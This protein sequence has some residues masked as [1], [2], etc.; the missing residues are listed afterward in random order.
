MSGPSVGLSALGKR[1]VSYGLPGQSAL[2]LDDL[3][4]ELAVQ[5]DQPLP[6]RQWED[7]L[8]E[9]R[10]HRVP[11]LLLAAIDD[12]ALPVTDDQRAAART[13]HLDACASV[14][15]LERRMLEIVTILEDAHV[16]VVV[17][18][19]SAHAHLMYDD[20]A[21]RHFGDVDLLVPSSQLGTAVRVL[22]DVRGAERTVPE[23][24]PG[25]DRRFAKS[26]T[27]QD[28]AGVEID[29]HRTLL[30][31]TFAFA[32]DE[33][34][35][36]ADT[37]EFTIGGRRLRTLGPEARLLHV[38]YHAGLGD[39]RP[40]GNSMRDLAQLWLAGQHDD[41]RLLALAARWRSEAV[42]AR[43][44]QLCRE[45]LDV[46]VPG[47]VAAQ[48]RQRIPA[49]HEARAIDSYVG[50]NRSHAA[51]VLA[52][53][54]FLRGVRARTAFVAASLVPS[55]RFV[56]RREG[57]R[58]AWLRRGWR[59]RPNGGAGSRSG[60]VGAVP[61]RR[62]R[63][64]WLTKGLGL[65]GAER[66]LTVMA[67]KLDPQRFELEVA[68]LLP[69]KDAFV[70]E[71]VESGV[72]VHCLGAA[73]T[74]DVSWVWR[75]RR[76]LRD[77]AF[78]VVHTHAP[79]PAAAARLLAPS[80]TRLVHTEH[81]VWDR[82]R[83]PTRVANAVTYGRNAVAF[84]VSDGVTASID[85]PRWAL[86]RPPA[87]RTLLHGVDA[88][89]VPRGAAARAVARERL[90]LADDD[91]VIGTVANLTPKKDQMTLLA[92]VDRLR[93]QHPSA[94]LCLVGSGPLEAEL[95]AEAR[96]RGL[97]A[98]VRFLGGR[99]D[100]Q[101]L[102]PAFDVFTLSSRFEGLPIS[103][104]E[105]MAAEVTVVVTAVGGI[106]EAITDG[107]DGRL[108]P[109]GDPDALAAAYAEVLGNRALGARLAAAGRERVVA[110]FSIDR[111]VEVTA[112]AYEQLLGPTCADGGCGCRGRHACRCQQDGSGPCQIADGEAS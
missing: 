13:V 105:A 30:F 78:D 86:G 48:L 60:W 88:D 101:E 45:V 19:G 1:V 112:G 46:E 111:A 83:V 12:R 15:G 51:K 8:L 96:R 18:K 34:D 97:G 110:D 57:G 87:T 50:R 75:L 65:G 100:V 106:P 52:S 103:M 10:Q 29:L 70:G 108:V 42:L 20:P 95:R 54:P 14:L 64:L 44:V 9:V 16:E 91:L 39:K 6:A 58:W 22:R 27:L 23:L 82:Y 11:G 99:D 24:R 17:L 53:L 81:N 41:A 3:P 67:P 69:W 74:V 56:A 40:R 38:S 4:A 109:P 59:S 76:L 104:L 26:V 25:F 55:G 66:L 21:L 80:G 32:I 94:V 36:F 90:G 62:L 85:P 47:P 33:A 107:H 7:L 31:G 84:G 92:A 89:G 43:G 5:P 68:Y 73:R 71:L 77:G 72:V 102:L 35:L 2:L 63:V 79:V 98:T 93:A 28:P 61:E 37:E 49:V